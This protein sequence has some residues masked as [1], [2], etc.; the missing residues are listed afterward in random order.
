VNKHLS[1]LVEL[2]PALKVCT[3]D[4]EKAFEVMSDSFHE[5]GKA[6]LCGNGGSAAD[7]EHWAAEL[8]KGFESK[9]PLDAALRERLGPS[10]ADALQGALP[11]IPLTG[12]P[13]LASA[14]ANDVRAELIFAQ[15][16]WGLGRKGDVLVGISTSGNTKNVCFAAQTAKAKGLMTVALTGQSGGRLAPLAQVAIRVPSDRTCEIQELHLP[17]YH[18]ISLMLEDEFFPA[19]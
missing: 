5:G 2:H 1:R 13:C 17:I 9:R 7:C 19:A 12:F 18:C 3:G 15:L 14:F 6:L 10:V 4:I 16:V 8:L 11:A